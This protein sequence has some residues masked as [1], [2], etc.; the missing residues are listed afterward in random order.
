MDRLIWAAK[1]RGLTAW[2]AGV[3][4]GRAEAEGHEFVSQARCVARGHA[5]AA[6][7][8][9]TLP[10]HTAPPHLRAQDDVVLVVAGR[11]ARD[12]AQLDEVH[13]AAKRG[14]GGWVGG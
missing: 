13:A 3:G 11:G 7:T 8:R 1:S 10:E 4:G 9:A 12:V 6:T 5:H 2:R 14:W